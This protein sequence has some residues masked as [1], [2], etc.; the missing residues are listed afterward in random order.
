MD[1]K[2]AE[3]WIAVK[4]Q[5]AQIE[6]L[7][8][9]GAFV[10]DCLEA[11]GLNLQ[12]KAIPSSS[13]AYTPP[14]SPSPPA[15]TPPGS[16]NSTSPSR[17]SP[18]SSTPT[19]V[20][21]CNRDRKLYV[22]GGHDGVRAL[23]SSRVLC[24]GENER[25][26]RRWEPLALASICRSSAAAVSLKDK[27]YVIG[28]RDGSTRLSSVEAFDPSV[29]RWENAPSLN[30]ARAGA[31]A[32]ILDSKIYVLGGE[33]S[34][35]KELS[36]VEHFAVGMSTPTWEKLPP[37]STPRWGLA[38]AAA[39]GRVYAMGGRVGTTRLTSVESF[40]PALSVW[41]QRPPL[42]EVRAAA[43]AT[44]A[45]GKIYIFGGFDNRG[46][47]LRSA[48]CFDPKK[49]AWDQLPSMKTARGSAAAVN[50]GGKIYVVGGQRG[51]QFINVVECFNTQTGKWEDRPPLQPPHLPVELAGPA[52]AAGS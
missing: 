39:Q 2:L 45:G 48:E 13:P 35:G 25:G 18:R 47:A 46:E 10:R 41:H 38:V 1:E 16:R 22:F 27:L 3:L 11:S 7:S 40:D 28:G 30:V 43:A 42:S 9:E 17:Q 4:G 37:M 21:N 29:G 8:S 26:L 33:D 20:E 49:N 5:Q 6:K 31:G 24:V 51:A 36:S 44:A 15:Y 23:N 52:A 34:T 50:V 32:A 12:R 19:R 14:D